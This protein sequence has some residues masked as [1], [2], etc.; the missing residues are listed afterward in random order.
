MYSML[1]RAQSRL[2]KPLCFV[3]QI[4]L[5]CH[6]FNYCDEHK[7]LATGSMFL[8]KKLHTFLKRVGKEEL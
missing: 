4:I 6:S 1:F 7:D 2:K 5:I 3:L 8:A